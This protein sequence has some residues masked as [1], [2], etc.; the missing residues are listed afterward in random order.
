MR[1]VLGFISEGELAALGFDKAGRRAL[2]FYLSEDRGVEGIGGSLAGAGLPDFGVEGFLDNLSAAQRPLAGLEHDGGSVEQRHGFAFGVIRARFARVGS[3]GGGGILGR[4][5]NFDGRCGDK[6]SQALGTLNPNDFAGLETLALP[7]TVGMF[8]CN[9][10]LGEIVGDLDQIDGV[11]FY[12]VFRHGSVSFPACASRRC[13]A[14][15]EGPLHNGLDFPDCQAV[16][17]FF[18]TVTGLQSRN[19]QFLANDTFE[20]AIHLREVHCVFLPSFSVGQHLQ[21]AVVI[22]YHGVGTRVPVEVFLQLE[23]EVPD[24]LFIVS[25]RP[26]FLFTITAEQQQTDI[27]VAGDAADS[28]EGGGQVLAFLGESGEFNFHNF[29]VNLS[30]LLA[31]AILLGDEVI[32]P[33]G[34]LVAD[35]GV[36]VFQGVPGGVELL[37][38]EVPEYLTQVAGIHREHLGEFGVRFPFS[39]VLPA[40]NLVF[41]SLQVVCEVGVGFHG[42][43]FLSLFGGEEG[44]ISVALRPVALFA[45]AVPDGPDFVVVVTPFPKVF[46][47][48]GMVVGVVCHL[49]VGFHYNSFLVNGLHSISTLTLPCFFPLIQSIK[50]LN[51]IILNNSG[52]A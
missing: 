50:A 39:L 11:D 4:L 32:E 47:V 15:I 9:F 48:G 14:G 13:G 22:V 6:F 19:F 30:F 46:I 34:H 44:V 43:V 42:L 35:Q 3:F 18:V 10:N 20:E 38:A 40:G 37:F 36:E 28:G 1:R 31:V 16:E 25:E 17:V 52:R 8:V 7:A 5:L 27:F 26:V 2:D 12:F 23:G 41:E 45:V 49:S 21:L 29:H 51:L 24:F 33:A